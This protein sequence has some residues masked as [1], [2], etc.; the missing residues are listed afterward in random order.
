M[1]LDIGSGHSHKTKKDVSRVK[2]TVSKSE[3]Q[4]FNSYYWGKMFHSPIIMENCV[5]LLR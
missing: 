4:D 3:L 2:Q 5:V 1:T